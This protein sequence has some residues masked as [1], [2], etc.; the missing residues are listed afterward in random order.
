MKHRI[1][2]QTGHYHKGLLL[3]EDNPRYIGPNL[4]DCNDHNNKNGKKK[5]I[6]EKLL[7]YS[8]C[9][10]LRVLDSILDHI[11]KERHQQCYFQ[12]CAYVRPHCHGTAEK[13]KVI[14]CGLYH[15][16]ILS[17]D[18]NAKHKHICH[19]KAKVDINKIWSFQL[20]S[21]YADIARDSNHWRCIN[22]THSLSKDVRIK[23]FCRLKRMFPST[24]EDI[25]T[26]IDCTDC[27]DNYAQNQRWKYQAQLVDFSLLH[28]SFSFSLFIFSVFI[29]QFYKHFHVFFVVIYLIEF[30]WSHGFLIWFRL[31]FSLPI[32]AVM[33]V[34]KT[35][36][37]IYLN[38]RFRLKL[39][40]F[41]TRYFTHYFLL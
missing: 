30:A 34:F 31:I 14:H 26:Q 27:N 3:D 22:H 16:I 36:I 24:V 28:I 41:W 29:C 18:I 21:V 11:L 32:T 35:S 2:E 6:A 25:M 7:F 1:V 8:I 17:K 13:T 23:V 4:I 33:S 15:L 10:L 20:S 37:S 5:V 38:L 9:F 40:F 19:F 39:N 12:V